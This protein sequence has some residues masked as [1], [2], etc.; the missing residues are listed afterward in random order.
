MATDLGKV[1]MR[2]RGDW[3]S[4]ATYE[5]LDA[6]T[7]NGA[8]YI[9]KQAVPANTLPTNTTY[10]QTALKTTS[11]ELDISNVRLEYTSSGATNPTATL[12]TASGAS[13]IYRNGNT[14][15]FMFI[16]NITDVGS[17]NTLMVSGL[18]VLA[19]PANYRVLTMAMGPALSGAGA[20]IIRNNSRDII[21]NTG[22]GANVSSSNLSTGTLYISGTYIT[23]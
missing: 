7:Y 23:N 15:T 5:V 17:G 14:V 22:A 19:T 20:G 6:V 16:F 2:M 11:Q 9:A 18:P 12:N 13:A 3:N 4:S 21:L 1:G 10:W 8:L